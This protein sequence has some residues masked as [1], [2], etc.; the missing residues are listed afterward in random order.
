[1][2]ANRKPGSPHVVAIAVAV[3]VKGS[4][5]TAIPGIPRSSHISASSTL[6]E[7][8]DPQSPMPDTT[9]SAMR[10]SVSA[11]SSVMP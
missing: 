8:H 4:V 2:L 11:D 7:L 3:G 9:K 6:L 5:I 1:M 10:R